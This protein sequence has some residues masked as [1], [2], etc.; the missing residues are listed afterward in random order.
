MKTIILTIMTAAVTATVVAGPPAATHQ[1]GP[2]TQ[3]AASRSAAGR[4]DFDWPA[5][6]DAIRVHENSVHFPYG[7]ERRINGRPV[8]FPEPAARRIC[9]RI[10]T[11]TYAQ[12]VTAGRKGDYFVALNGHYAADTNW[13]RDTKRIYNR[14]ITAR[15]ST[16]LRR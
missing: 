12:W 5:L 9:L 14:L 6:A 15:A 4:D 11:E 8:G 2:T 13:W 1:H 7:A 3:T 16:S 10:C